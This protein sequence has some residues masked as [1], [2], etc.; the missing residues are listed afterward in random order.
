MNDENLS[1]AELV[2][3]VQTGTGRNEAFDE[4]DRRYRPVLHRF[5]TRYTFCVHQAE[6]LVQQTLI[7]GFEMLGQLQSG[8]KLA[9]WLHRI[10]FRLTVAEGRKRRMTSLD[11]EGVSEPAVELDDEVQRNEERRNIWY[12]AETKLSEEDYEILRLRYREDLNC[13]DIAK[14]VGKTETAVRVQLHRARKKLLPIF[15]D[16]FTP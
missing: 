7:R 8:E 2:R 14:K 13:T 11:A 4:I 16:E 10:A 12:I 15:R 6:E 9:G 5:I 1:D 3:R